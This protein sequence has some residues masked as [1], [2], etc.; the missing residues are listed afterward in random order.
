MKIIINFFNLIKSDKKTKN[1]TIFSIILMFIFTIGYSLSIFTGNKNYNVA[2]INVN[3]LAF[4]ITTNSGESD[5][6][7]L[8]LKAGKTESFDIT[9]TNLNNIDTNYELIYKI[10]NNFDCTQQS[11]VIKMPDGI[12]IGLDTSYQNEVT[13]T[14][15][16]GGKV[17]VKIFTENSTDSDYYIILGMQAGYIW[18]DLALLNLFDNFY[19]STSIIAYVEGV[20]VDK[21]PDSCSY[22]PSVKAYKN[23]E[24]ITLNNLSVTCDKT[25]KEWQTLYSNYADKIE[26]NFTKINYSTFANDS[27]QTISDVVTYID[28]TIYAVGSEKEVAIDGI[29]YTVRVVNNTTPSECNGSDFSHTACGFVVEFVDIPET[30]LMNSTATNVGGWP[31]SSLRTYANGDF[32]KKLPS[33]L[34]NVIIDTKVVSG[35]GTSNTSNFTSTDKLYL[36]SAKEIWNG[37]SYDTALNNTRQLDYYKSKGV[38]TSSYNAV[39]KIRNGTN[40]YWW[41][42]TSYSSNNSS[43]LFVQGNGSWKSVTA[44]SVY[45][46][47]P[48]FRLGNNPFVYPS[49]ST[50]S[51]TTTTRTTTT[52]TTTKKTT[53]TTTTS[54]TKKTTT[55][56]TTKPITYSFSS[57][58]WATIA[59]NVKAGNGNKYKVGDEKEVYINGSYYTVRLANNTTPSVCGN[60]NYSQ[61]ACGFVVEFVDIV[62]TRVMNNTQV[63]ADGWA[64]STY[65]AIRAYANGTFLRSLPSDL[66][67]VIVDTKVISGLGSGSINVS[68]VTTTTDKIYLLSGKEVLIDGTEKY[69]ISHYDYAYNYT[70]QLDYYASKGVTSNSNSNGIYKYYQNSTS[71]WWLRTACALDCNQYLYISSSSGWSYSYPNV[72]NGFAPAFRIG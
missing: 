44:T 11:D 37:N 8:H 4:N 65:G 52:T 32:L 15:K 60:S 42:R 49:S 6:R 56:T 38:T 16:V 71:S 9:I 39:I 14:L 64:N 51:T 67:N 35:H 26:V 61:T 28:P 54:T 18:N 21:Y 27:W 66:Q 43:F 24:E 10:C 62:E 34:Q 68:T 48:A 63:N 50:T 12:N 13:G 59:N 40:T 36:F 55:T 57:D 1:L 47:A 58:S 69:P 3:D 31:A 5:D 53:T 72:S 45:S 22:K 19:K 2:N 25:T 29:N 70:R 23:G 46:F 17:H 41:L 20:E 33:D 7:V 30:R